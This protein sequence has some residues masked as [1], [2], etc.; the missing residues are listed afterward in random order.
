MIIDELP[1]RIGQA[2]EPWERD[3]Q[4]GDALWGSSIGDCREKQTYRLRAEP[5]E[6]VSLTGYLVREMGRAIHWAIEGWFRNTEG[7][8]TEHKDTRDRIT[9]KADILKIGE[10]VVEIKTVNSWVWNRD[11]TEDYLPQ[12]ERWQGL[13]TSYVHRVFDVEFWWIARDWFFDEKKW[14]QGL[15]PIKAVSMTRRGTHSRIIL[16]RAKEVLDAADEGYL[17]PRD[18][19]VPEDPMCRFC[20][21]FKPCWEGDE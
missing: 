19:A 13:V 2:L 12:N 16:E 5:R 17:L 18:A 1:D 20:D 11:I 7:Y 14:P 9:A 15:P 6:P 8:L 10:T 4:E 3:W 21:Y